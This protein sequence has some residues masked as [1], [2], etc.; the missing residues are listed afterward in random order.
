MHEVILVENIRA[1]L[2][3]LHNEKNKFVITEGLWP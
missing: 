3:E 1:I 2:T